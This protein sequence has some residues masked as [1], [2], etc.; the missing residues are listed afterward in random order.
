[1]GSN[2]VTRRRVLQGAV[3]LAGVGTAA[4]LTAFAQSGQNGSIRPAAQPAARSRWLACSTGRV[5]RSPAEGD[6]ARQDDHRQHA[7][8]RRARLHYIDSARIIR[9]LAK[10]HGGKPEATI[11]FDGTKLPV[12]EA[13]RVNAMLSDAAASDDSDIRNTAHTGTTLVRPASPSPSARAPRARICSAR[14]SS[15]TRRRAGS[16]RRSAAAGRG[17]HA[18]QIVAFGGAVAAARL[19]KLTDEQMAHAIGITAMTMGGL[20]IG[21]NSWAREYM[22]GQRGALRRQRRAGRRPRLHGQRGHA[23]SARADSSTVFGGGEPDT[24]RSTRDLGKEWDIV[25]YLAIKLWPGAH[26]FSRHGGS[27]R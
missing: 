25:E 24:E 8:Q 12:H 9:E 20:A 2:H 22:G 3:A 4:R 5:R 23:G 14:W 13:A 18:S 16:A 26:P 15:A 10:E 27:G 19:L 7:G 1:M 21:T 6:R 17:V 11:W